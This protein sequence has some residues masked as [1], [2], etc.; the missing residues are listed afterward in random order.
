MRTS[1]LRRA[2]ISA[3]AIGAVVT[4]ASCSTGG[5]STAPAST[6]DS[7]A[8][9]GSRVAISYDGGILVLDGETLDTVADFESEPFTRLSPAGDDRHVMVTMSEGFQVLDTA[10]GSADKAE[11]TDLVFDADAPGHVVRHAGK[12]VL[13]ADGTSDTTIFDS[14]DLGSTDGL[15]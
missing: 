5:D 4:L 9:A 2:L 11:L 15:P 7:D 13:Y 6:A 12:T 8:P 1:P 10:A 3:A 14:A